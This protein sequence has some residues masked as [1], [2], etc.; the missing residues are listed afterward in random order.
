M[1]GL[2]VLAGALGVVYL[3]VA[4]E[5]LPSYLGGV[6]GD[7]DPRTKLGVAMLFVAALLFVVGVIS[8][9]RPR[10]TRE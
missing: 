4:C 7:P 1:L 3:V 8:T 10:R 5:S 2:A 6:A 9:R